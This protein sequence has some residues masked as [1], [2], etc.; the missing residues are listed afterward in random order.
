[1]KSL[2]SGYRLPLPGLS[3]DELYEDVL[4]KLTEHRAR[5]GKTTSHVSFSDGDVLVYETS[6]S[7]ASLLQKVVKFKVSEVVQ[8]IFKE[9]FVSMTNIPENLQAA[10]AFG[11][12]LKEFLIDLDFEDQERLTEELKDFARFK[13]FQLNRVSD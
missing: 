13:K 2:D 11:E 6:R 5:E 8:G 10:S 1:M 3:H 4:D 9:E 12:W 7:D